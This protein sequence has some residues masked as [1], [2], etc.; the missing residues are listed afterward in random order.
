MTHETFGS[1]GTGDSFTE[2][3]KKAGEPFSVKNKKDG[4]VEYLYIERVWMGDELVYLN[5]YYVVVKNGMVV[6]KRFKQQKQP[7]YNLIYEEDPN[8]DN[9]L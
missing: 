8:D 5:R 2:V 3:E 1:I 9:L 4:S 7:A 6:S